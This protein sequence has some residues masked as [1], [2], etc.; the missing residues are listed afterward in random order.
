MDLPN[1]IL[2]ATPTTAY[3]GYTYD[4]KSGGGASSPDSGTQLGANWLANLTE[5][6]TGDVEPGS[7]RYRQLVDTANEQK[8]N[9]AESAKSR[10]FNLW[11]D[12][13]KYQR[14]V[15]DME[16][17]GLNPLLM[18]EGK[19]ISATNTASSA[20]SRASKAD[21]TVRHRNIPQ[22]VTNAL[23]GISSIATTALAVVKIAT[24]LL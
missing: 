19:G 8:Y 14:G 16:K 18:A 12:S 2:D 24:L 9:S 5:K 13:T 17:A 7:D 6:F 4:T 3:E 11:T 21:S 20:A 1:D 23:K 15:E 10:L 22:D